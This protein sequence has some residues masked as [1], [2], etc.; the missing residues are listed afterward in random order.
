MTVFFE[1][2]KDQDRYVY[3]ILSDAK[4]MNPLTAEQQIADT[5]KTICAQCCEQFTRKN[6]VKTSLSPERSIHMSNL[7]HLQFKIKI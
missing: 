5:R 4:P 1:Y 7:Q 6:K 3:S 2:V